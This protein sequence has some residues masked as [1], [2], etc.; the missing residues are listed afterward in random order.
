MGFD[1]IK[2]T[3]GVPLTGVLGFV[4]C[5]ADPNAAP[6]CDAHRLPARPE[7]QAEGAGQCH[8]ILKSAR[9]LW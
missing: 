8:S 5:V 3:F 9:C 6:G 2:R 7:A 1:T 4:T